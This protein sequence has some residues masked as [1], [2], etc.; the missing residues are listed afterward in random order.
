MSVS[1]G[2][3]RGGK[4]LNDRQLAADLRTMAMSECMRHLKAKKGKMYEMVLSKLAGQILPRIQEIS[5]DSGSQ[6][7]INVVRYTPPEIATP[8]TPTPEPSTQAPNDDEP[9]V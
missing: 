6:L 9:Q 5:G 2:I 1:K 7:Q 4:T 3:G 8:P